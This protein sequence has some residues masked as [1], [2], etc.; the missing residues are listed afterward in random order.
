M[1][2][3]DLLRR[4]RATP[5]LAKIATVLCSG[6]DSEAKPPG[7]RANFWLKGSDG[8]FDDVA[9]LGEK[10][11]GQGF[12]IQGSGVATSLTPEP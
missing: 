9:R 11:K 10:L 12:R 4:I 2:G 5:L 6:D 1:S 3:M 7:G 8:M